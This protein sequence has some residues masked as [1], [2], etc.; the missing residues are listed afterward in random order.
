MS[1]SRAASPSSR[2]PTPRS[3]A[4]ERLAHSFGFDDVDPD[5]KAGLVRGVFDA[6]RP[7]TT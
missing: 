7:A 4:A 6:W 5:E 1:E 2:Q 3:G